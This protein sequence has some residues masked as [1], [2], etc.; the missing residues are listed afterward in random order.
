MPVLARPLTGR[1]NAPE[2]GKGREVDAGPHPAENHVGWNLADDIR[3]EEDENDD[4]VLGGRQLEVFL[5]PACLCVAY[6]G[7]VDIGQE[8]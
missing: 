4:G 5:K 1:G 6:I 2:D 7:A 8:V 3:C